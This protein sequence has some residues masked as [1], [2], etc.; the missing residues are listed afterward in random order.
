MS[1]DN[2]IEEK[3]N[4]LVK[5]FTPEQFAQLS[6]IF[7]MY[8]ELLHRSAKLNDAILELQKIENFLSPS[9]VE[10]ISE[11]GKDYIYLNQKIKQMNSTETLH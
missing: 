10:I 8:T 6:N 11:W 3:V 9:E 1:K 2:S 5:N 4:E 7:S